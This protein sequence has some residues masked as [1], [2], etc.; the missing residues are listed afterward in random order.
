MGVGRG[1]RLGLAAAVAALG[2]TV[3]AA[4]PAHEANVIA[5]GDSEATTAA[6]QLAPQAAPQQIE[7]ASSVW[8]SSD[9]P[10]IGGCPIFPGDNTWNTRVDC[11]PVNAR[12]ADWVAS[13]GAGGHVHPDF[14][15][16]RDGAPIGILFT[17]VGAGEPK[18]PV[19]FD[20]AD[21]SDRGPFS[22]LADAPIEGGG[23]INHALRFTVS[24]T[25]RG[26][27]APATHFASSSSDPTRAGTTTR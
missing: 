4:P 10:V 15:T 11:L 7:R 14:G 22:I 23:A 27:I 17:T 18:G 21:E 9:G 19:T 1:G 2:V 3:C 13:I 6:G 12:S 5:L 8:Y 16:F 20:H 25:Q 26:Y 24:R